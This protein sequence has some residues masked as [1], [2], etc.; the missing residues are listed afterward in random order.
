MKEKNS[1][2]LLA[3]KKLNVEN[4]ENIEKLKKLNSEKDE[5]IYVMSS[6]I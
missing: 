2:E 4:Q 6:Y 3:L 5:Q 1:L